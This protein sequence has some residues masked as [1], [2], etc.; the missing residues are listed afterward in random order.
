MGSARRGQS[1]SSG[2]WGKQRRGARGG[3][4]R[5]WGRE[6]GKVRDLGRKLQQ[7]RKIWPNARGG[8]DKPGH[9]ALGKEM[10]AVRKCIAHG[11]LIPESSE[12]WS[13]CKP[14]CLPH[15]S[16]LFFYAPPPTSTGELS[17][18]AQER[19]VQQ[20][21]NNPLHGRTKT[22][23]LPTKTGRGARIDE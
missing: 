18:S 11:A 7:Y 6:T 19:C 17:I 16:T 5:G 14:S 12:E 20:I 9:F 1:P 2:R 23:G 22:L 8:M 4:G 3:K 10:G 13:D 21:I 15:L